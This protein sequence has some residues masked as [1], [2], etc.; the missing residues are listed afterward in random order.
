[1][2]LFLTGLLIGMGSSLILT[3]LGLLFHKKI[4]DTK[5]RRK[6]KKMIKNGEFL[7]PIDEKDYNSKLWES[8]IDVN[9][10]REELENLNK[11]IFTSHVNP[12]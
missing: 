11:Q 10:N 8:Y 7:T 1:M 5:E 2:G 6:I 9:K 12:K 4:K 3:P